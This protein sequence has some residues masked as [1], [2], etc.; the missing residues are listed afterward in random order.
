MIILASTTDNI[1][2]VLASAVTTNQLDCTSSW[3]D[4][5]TT[6]YT[7]GRT[8]VNTNNT[9]D[10]NIVPAPASN[11]QRV[12]DFINV[13]NNDTATA[14][15]T[16]KY[17]VSGIKYILWKGSLLPGEN[18]TYQEGTGFVVTSQ[19]SLGYTLSVQALTSSPVDG[20][21]IF[22]G[23]MPKAPVAT[24]GISR[25]Y[26]P[27]SGRIK[28]AEIYCY[29]G[30][31]GTAEAWPGYIRINNTTDFLIA[32][33]SV[34]TNDRIYSNSLLD[35]PVVVGDYIEIKFVNPTWATNPLTTIFGGY[36]YIE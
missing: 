30:T 5:T 14:T 34:A 33:L 8:V 26:I 10:V 9:T 29:S 7:P 32:T 6:T 22:F 21:I 23:N 1:Q 2:V 25:V 12:V 36:V 11:T 24:G 18:V 4:I 27:K 20:Q 19:K 16:I 17:D 15:V 35:I 31:A 13:Y 3:R 28:R